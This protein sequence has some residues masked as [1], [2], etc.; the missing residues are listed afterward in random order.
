LFWILRIGP[1]Y[2]V[3]CDRKAN[4]LQYPK[5]DAPLYRKSGL[6]TQEP[7]QR[8]QSQSKAKSSESSET[9]ETTPSEK[10]VETPTAVPVGNFIKSENSLVMKSKRLTRF[11]EKYR[12]AVVRKILSGSTTLS[13]VREDKKLSEGEIIDWIADLFDR[14]QAKID[15][16]SNS[17]E[18]YIDGLTTTV[19]ED[20]ST[21]MPSRPR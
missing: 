4:F 19:K 13:Q 8:P 9:A 18:P 11:S 3:H 20:D 21:P 12:D 5:A 16:L 2:C 15:S 7:P 17:S 1:W 14:Q 6:A 10:T